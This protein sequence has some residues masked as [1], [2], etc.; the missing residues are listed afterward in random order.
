MAP[1]SCRSWL[2]SP[3]V[4]GSSICRCSWLQSTVSVVVHGSGGSS[5]CCSWWLQFWLCRSCLQYLSLVAPVFVAC[6][7]SICRSCCGVSSICRSLV[8]PVV[9]VA[10]APVTVA[11]G[12]SIISCCRSWLHWL[13]FMAPVSVV[14]HGSSI[15][16]LVLWLRYLLLQWLQY[17]SIAF[18][19]TS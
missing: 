18:G 11:C 14:R 3:V 4:C 19:S 15:C 10:V 7:S 1:V 12:S 17:L 16:R 9:V 5:I 6:G 8:A 13:S 2:Q